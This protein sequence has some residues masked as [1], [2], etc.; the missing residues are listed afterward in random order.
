MEET[1][2]SIANYLSLVVEVL[3]A[4]V[5]G[6]ALLQFLATYIPSLFKKDQ[7]ISNT[8]LRVKF[9]SSLAIA[10]ELLLAADILQTAVAPTWDDIGKLAAIAAIRTALNYFLEKELREI[11]QRTLA[12]QRSAATPKE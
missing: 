7:H 4:L 3:G 8:W 10:L 1:A 6:I 9:G 2:K 5:I 11:E 12:E